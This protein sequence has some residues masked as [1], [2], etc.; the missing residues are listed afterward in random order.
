MSLETSVK[1]E[2]NITSEAVNGLADFIER[3]YIQPNWSSIHQPSYRRTLFDGHAIISWRFDLVESGNSIFLY[4]HLELS[5]SSIVVTFRNLDNTNALQM[6]LYERTVDEVR[7]IISSFFQNARLSSLYFVV[8]SDDEN[9][10][11]APTKEG[12]T[13]RSLLRR[14]LLGNNANVFLI[15]TLLGIA[16]LLTI[17]LIG[18]LFMLTAQFLYLVYSDKLIL[19]TGNVRPN[20]QRPLVS[21]VSLRCNQETQR[22]L[23]QHGKKILKEIRGD[24]NEL[25]VSVSETDSL[26]RN[27]KLKASILSALQRYGIPA[28]LDDLQVLTKN[29]YEIVKTV[30]GKFNQPIPKIVIANSVI[31]NA[32][33]T[34]ISKK[35]STIMITAGA[36]E[37]LS[38]EELAAT[39]GHE[40]GHIKGH[41]PLILFGVTSF[42]FV[43][44]FYLW[45][46]LVAY[47]GFFYFILAFAV[48]FGFGKVLE[49]RA[50]TESAIVLGDA[51]IF[52]RSLRKIAFRELYLEKY[53]PLARLFDWFKF[54][55]HPPTY[56]R[57]A[58][59]SKLVAE[60]LQQR[61]FKHT[62]LISLR[63]CIVGFISAFF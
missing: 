3:Y 11:E 26:S 46:P 20:S 62:F 5:E 42:Q 33:S 45:Y 37:D 50:D 14:I 43:G 30:A 31:S 22:Y 60:N 21:V 40:L 41:D 38:D 57:V 47:L 51:L 29:V 28:A 13:K 54:D 32:A 63:D 48:I 15:F 10:S 18:L 35:R 56:F 44:M 34:G 52:A 23:R 61:R 6:K 4:C 59:M 39:I 53:S 55:P 36:L 16:L 24:V 19:N 8:G 9:Y 12:G 7:T 2:S 17:G 58:R 49:T 1:I 27:R 25:H